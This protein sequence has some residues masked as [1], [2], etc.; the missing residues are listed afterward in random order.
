MGGWRSFHA[1]LELFCFLGQEKKEKDKIETSLNTTS[2]F[3]IERAVGQKIILQYSHL[4]FSII[5]GK[6]LLR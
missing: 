3:E 2:L 5:F 4:F 6:I 1:A